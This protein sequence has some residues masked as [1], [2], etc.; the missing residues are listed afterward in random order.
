MSLCVAGEWPEKFG[1]LANL[2]WAV[3][4]SLYSSSFFD[5]VGKLFSL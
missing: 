1:S 4:Q 2:E 5:K 3:R